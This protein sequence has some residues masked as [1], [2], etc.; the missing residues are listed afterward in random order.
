MLDWLDMTGR[1]AF[2][3][4]SSCGIGLAFAVAFAKNGA[5]ISLIS[6]NEDD[7]KNAA[8]TVESLG[9]KCISH[10]AAINNEKSV[11]AAVEDTIKQFGR[12]D[13]LINNTIPQVSS[14]PLMEVSAEEFRNVVD[15]TV[16]GTF[17][18]SR[19]VAEQMIRQNFGRIVNI[20]TISSDCCSGHVF[21]GA[22]EISKSGV[23][24]MS[25]CMAYDWSKYNILINTITPGYIDE[26][27]TPRENLSADEQ[28]YENQIPLGRFGTPEEVANIG[29]FLCSDGASYTQCTDFVVDGGRHLV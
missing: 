19:I 11:R 13:Y 9:V 23:R 1:T 21:P 22:Y 25:K 3:S 4:D 5:N 24:T 27:H 15:T 29:V 12:L 2:I 14:K 17:Q 16:A 7:L 18:V 20:A 28:D 26:K 8:A 6:E 10:V